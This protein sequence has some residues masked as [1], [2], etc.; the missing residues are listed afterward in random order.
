[1]DDEREWMR[2]TRCMGEWFA[3]TIKSVSPSSK[4][5]N[6]ANGKDMKVKFRICHFYSHSLFIAV[7]IN[8]C[9]SITLSVYLLSI[10]LYPSYYVRFGIYNFYSHSLFIIGST[11]MSIYYSISLPLFFYSS[12]LY[13]SITI[14]VHFPY[15]FYILPTMSIHITIPLSV[16]ISITL[17]LF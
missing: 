3:G 7:S 8:I 11:N 1:M 9:L 16:H 17:H 14:S 4:V 5:I 10:F 6:D 12:P 15:F 2:V 13:L